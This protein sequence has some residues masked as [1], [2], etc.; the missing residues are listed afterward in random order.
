MLLSDFGGNISPMKTSYIAP[1]ALLLSGFFY[2][3]A[4]THAHA[5]SNAT[6]IHGDS[7][8]TESLFFSSHNVYSS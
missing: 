7:K 5:H 4:H 3:H 2:I 6:N 8:Q 1:L